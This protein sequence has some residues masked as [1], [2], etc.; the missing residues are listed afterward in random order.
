MRMILCAAALS[1]SA[2]LASA[3]TIEA[4]VDDYIAMPQI[5]TMMDDMFAP[6]NLGKQF[7]S[8]LPPTVQVSQAQI[9][10]V[11]A[12]MSQG[13]MK[14]RPDL[15]LSMRKGMMQTFSVAEVRA[16]IGFYQS[17]EGASVMAKMAPFMQQVMAEIAPMTQ[18]TMRKNM[19]KIMAIISPK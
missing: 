5:Q 11:G 14:I 10:Q 7:A 8:G 18:E 1:L 9:K 6:D 2:S 17:P 15:E 19:P 13:M 4:A 16:L 3:D 12:V